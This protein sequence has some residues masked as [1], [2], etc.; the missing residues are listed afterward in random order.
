VSPFKSRYRSADAAF[1][2][3]QVHI[4]WLLVFMLRQATRHFSELLNFLDNSEML[5]SILNSL[6]K[7]KGDLMQSIL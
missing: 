6:C 2:W 1:V 5:T 3:L 7:F 4:L